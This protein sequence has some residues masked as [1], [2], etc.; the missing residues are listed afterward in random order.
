M[1]TKFMVGLG[2]IVAAGLFMNAILPN[3]AQIP[4]SI[5]L[6]IGVCMGAIY[7]HEEIW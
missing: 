3:E 4:C 2:M 1:I 5:I 6:I 7:T